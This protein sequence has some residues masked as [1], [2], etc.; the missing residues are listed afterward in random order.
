MWL[1]GS[2]LCAVVNV[3]VKESNAQGKQIEGFIYV[4]YVLNL[5]ND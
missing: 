2:E 5:P 1:I 3:Q 4:A